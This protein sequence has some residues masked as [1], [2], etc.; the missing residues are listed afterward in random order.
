M[1]YLAYLKL[2]AKYSTLMIG[3]KVLNETFMKENIRYIVAMDVKTVLDSL[4]ADNDF[5]FTFYV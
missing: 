1:F 5:I 3:W 4:F 2:I